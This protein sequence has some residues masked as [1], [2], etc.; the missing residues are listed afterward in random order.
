[1]VS[2]VGLFL[3]MKSVSLK[4]GSTLLIVSAAA[5]VMMNI[6]TMVM[7]GYLNACSAR[8]V[9]ALAS[10]GSAFFMGLLGLNLRRF[11]RSASM[12]RRIAVTLSVMIRYPMMTPLAARI[13]KSRTAGM[14]LIRFARKLAAVVSAARNSGVPVCSTLFCMA[15]RVLLPWWSASRYRVVI[16]MP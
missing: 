15:S 12:L 1:M 6:V 4:L 2:C 5:P 3:L 7:M 8:S 13:A 16:W 9:I 11:S 14:S 10:P